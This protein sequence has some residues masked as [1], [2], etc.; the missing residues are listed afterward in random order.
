MTDTPKDE[1]RGAPETIDPRLASFVS[2]APVAVA[3]FD[4]RM[5]YAA[6]SGFW[7]EHYGIG[8]RD[9]Y[10]QYHYDILPGLQETLL[11]AHQRA[12][13]GEHVSCQEGRVE[14][15]D[16]REVWERWHIKP[17]SASE[18][19]IIGT[20]LF[21]EDITER[22]QA[23]ARLHE[24]ETRLRLVIDALGIG[25]VEKDYG[26]GETV[27]SPTFRK[28]IGLE[29][30]ALPGDLEGWAEV[31]NPANPEGFRDARRHA[32][33]PGGNGL[34]RADLQPVVNGRKREMSLIGR[35]LFAGEDDRKTASRFVGILIDQTE[36]NDLQ[37]SLAR[38]QRLEA[39]GR[40]SGIIAHD[41][42]NLLSVILANL[43]LAALNVSDKTTCEHLRA[44]IDAA[45]M[46]GGFNKKLL[47]LSG[48]KETQPVQI[49]LDD[50]ILRTWAMLE[51]L[52]NEHVSLHF[53]PSAGDLCVRIDPAELDGA[54]LNLVVNARDAQPEGGGEITIAT[55]QVEIDEDAAKT[56]EDGKP[57]KFLELSVSDTGTGMSHEEIARAKEPFFT[58]KPR[59]MGVGLGLTSVAATVAHV[60]GFISIDSGKGRG[61]TVSLFLPIDECAAVQLATPDETPFGNGELVLVVEDDALVREAT[62]KRLEALGYAVMEAP[63]GAS[64]LSALSESEAIDLVFA[65]VVLPGDISGDDIAAHVRS[66]CPQVGVLLTS[67]HTSKPKMPGTPDSGR[68]ELLKKPYPLS[69]LARAVERTLN[70]RG[71][72]S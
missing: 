10:G 52:L 59:E 46:G 69:V 31:L 58:S 25:I 43:E 55:R 1:G 14:T 45:E 36:R 2:G 24:S 54:I 11:T 41:F 38:S 15:W 68:H 27:V 22:K 56:Y 19:G 23:E 4:R 32:L 13:A 49:A 28:M 6:W 67:G 26:T 8:D 53:E 65:D 51:R 33:D 63:D 35:V 57:G 50:H 21:A 72:W 34:F 61:T 7:A 12:L 48:S 66:H 42:N 64:A 5:R 20:A 60:D 3:M 30:D 37:V 62:L 39:V 18:G 29:G 16:G 9:L 44:A 70:S 47:A 71:G 17:I 40:I